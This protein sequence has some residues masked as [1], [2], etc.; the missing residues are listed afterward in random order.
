MPVPP[1]QRKGDC[2]RCA[3]LCCIAYAAEKSPG[4]AASKQAGELCPKLDSSGLCTI[5]DRREK[6][7]FSGCMVYDCFGA[8]Q[9]VVQQLYQG[10]HWRDD[11]SLLAP[12]LETFRTMRKA[13]ELLYLAD[14]ARERNLSAEQSIRLNELDAQLHEITAKREEANSDRRLAKIESELRSLVAKL[15]R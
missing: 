12:M 1:I 6:E 3:A 5:Y 13:H 15:G 8:G 14:Y 11:A 9:H 7:G 10:R 4:F 2:D